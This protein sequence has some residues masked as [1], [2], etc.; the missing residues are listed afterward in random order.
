MEATKFSET[1]V[2]IQQLKCVIYQEDLNAKFIPLLGLNSVNVFSKI[3]LEIRV[4]YF[5]VTSRN[6]AFVPDAICC[7]FSPQGQPLKLV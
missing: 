4:S 5:Q 6:L 2:N 3:L 1:S 7:F